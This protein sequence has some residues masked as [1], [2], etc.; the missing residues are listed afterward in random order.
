MALDPTTS[1]R[2]DARAIAAALVAGGADVP[3]PATPGWDLGRLVKHVGVVLAWQ[4]ANVERRPEQV[5]PRSLDLGIPADRADYGRWLVELADRSAAVLEAAPAADTCW[6]WTDDRTVAFWSRRLHHEVSVHRWDAE[7]A[8]GTPGAFD[9]EDAA[10]AIDELLTVVVHRA[11]VPT[12]G[13]G[14]TIH[15]HAT[16]A[17][18]EW[19]ITRGAEGMTVTRE[20]AKGDV[21]VR[22]GAGDLLLVIL[23]RA[24]IET[25][26]V[27]G[28]PTVL[29][30]WR[31]EVRF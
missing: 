15:L 28:D 4:A 18:G 31:A 25:V 11:D 22:G 10:D 16:D 30:A 27:L 3:V 21:A 17:T 19:L 6:T 5:E 2:R 14:E 24:G 23:G 7:A 12:A 8:V 29:E 1:I 26:E 13:R 20:H 9:P